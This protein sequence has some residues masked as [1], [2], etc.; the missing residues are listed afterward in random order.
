MRDRDCARI[1]LMNKMSVVSLSKKGQKTYADSIPCFSAKHNG[2]LLSYG[3][4]F[5]TEKEKICRDLRE[6]ITAVPAYGKLIN[7]CVS[8]NNEP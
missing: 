6:P 5:Y 3:K 2:T 4:Y 7:T 8:S 1:S